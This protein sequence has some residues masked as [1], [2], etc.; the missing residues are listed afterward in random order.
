MHTLTP[1]PESLRPHPDE[2]SGL[3]RGNQNDLQVC[4]LSPEETPFYIGD[5]DFQTRSRDIKKKLADRI[6][7]GGGKGAGQSLA[8]T[9]TCRKRKR[10]PSLSFSQYI[11]ARVCI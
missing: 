6:Q 2:S 9:V 3:E 4:L 7:L 5:G 10:Q 8:R 11:V 1:S